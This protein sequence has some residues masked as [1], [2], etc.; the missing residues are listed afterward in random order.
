MSSP[1]AEV[2]ADFRDY[3]Q[4]NLRVNSRAEIST[5][6]VIAKE[7]TEHAQAISSELENHI[8]TVSSETSLTCPILHESICK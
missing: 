8:R 3:L 5:L 6:T 2:A 1:A 4:T 7:N